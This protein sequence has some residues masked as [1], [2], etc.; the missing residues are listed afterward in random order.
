MLRNHFL[1]DA[2][3]LAYKFT[4]KKIRKGIKDTK[5]S[6]LAN[7]WY[8]LSGI[9]HDDVQAAFIRDTTDAESWI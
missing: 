4:A 7:A 1:K 6:N 5:M 3:R 9:W 8:A 2:K